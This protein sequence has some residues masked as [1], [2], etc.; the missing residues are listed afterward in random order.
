MLKVKK[1]D[2]SS[3]NPSLEEISTALIKHCDMNPIGYANWSSFP[4]KPEVNFLIGHSSSEI[5]LQY[6]VKEKYIRAKYTCDNDS[7][8]TD[9]CVEFFFSPVDDGSY[10]NLEFN[11]I[12][13]AL[14]GF[15]YGKPDRE[16]ADID[17]LKKIKRSSTLGNKSIEHSENDFTWSIT[18][19]IPINVFYKHSLT[20]FSGLMCKAN[21]YK[22]G[23]ELKESHY[24][25][26]NPIE[27]PVPNFHKPEFFGDLKFE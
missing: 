15:G 16:R 18:I 22:C 12:G 20:S 4:Y 1:L 3:V 26:W 10:Y 13:T 5:Y 23:D 8:W 17:I 6:I 19:S 24:L 7:V 25:S 27:S 11:C 21:F 14:L 2:L 9:S